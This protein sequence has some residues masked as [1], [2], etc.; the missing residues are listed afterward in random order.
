MARY[1]ALGGPQ[2]SGVKMALA[3]VL[4]LREQFAESEALLRDCLAWFDERGDIAD[5]GRV[6]L[7]LLPAL[8]WKGDWARWDGHIKAGWRILVHTGLVDEELASCA[9]FAGDMAAGRDE[10]RWARHAWDLARRL[11]ERAGRMPDADGVHKSLPGVRALPR[12]KES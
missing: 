2:S 8:A 1:D 4:A 10:M 3:Q 6:H 5:A 7:S 11:F 12:L 9:R